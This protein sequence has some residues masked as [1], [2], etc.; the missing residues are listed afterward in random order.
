MDQ[1]KQNEISKVKSYEERFADMMSKHYEV[2]TTHFYNINADFR[3][4]LRGTTSQTM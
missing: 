1:I 2:T 4:A 3:P